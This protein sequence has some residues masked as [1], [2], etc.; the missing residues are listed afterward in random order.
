MLNKLIAGTNVE[1]YTFWSIIILHVHL[2]RMS[3]KG[4]ITYIQYISYT[5]GTKYCAYA[6]ICI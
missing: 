5:Q 1:H 6:H 4:L 3:H 2:Y